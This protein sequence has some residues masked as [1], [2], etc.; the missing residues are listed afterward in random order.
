MDDSKKR[1]L[2]KKASKIINQI[3]DL[4]EK[5]AK[6]E[7]AINQLKKTLKKD[8]DCSSTKDAKK[9]LVQMEKQEVTTEKAL[10]KSM[11]IF[12]EKWEE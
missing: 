7:G 10:E 6:A 9:K 5:A 3:E 12:D 8:L 11:K 4:K 2:L 1:K